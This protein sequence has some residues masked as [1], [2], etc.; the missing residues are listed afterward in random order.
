MLIPI[1]T[2]A[3][4]YHLP[5]MTVGLIALNTALFFLVGHPQ[6][7]M[8]SIG[9]GWH[10]LQWVTSA[11]LHANI[12]H[13]IGNMFFLW[14][15]GLVVEGKIG[16][17]RYLLTYLV[18]AVSGSFAAQTLF[19]FGGSDGQIRYALGASGAISGLMAIALLWAPENTFTVVAAYKY[20]PFASAS[21]HE[22]GILDFSLWFI[23]WDLFIAVLN[24]FPLS[25]P[26]LHLLGVIV[27][28]AVGVTFLQFRWVDCEKYDLFT[29]WSGT[30]GRP[31]Q[32]L[33]SIWKT[34]T[35]KRKKSS[36]KN[37]QPRYKVVLLNEADREVEP[38]RKPKPRQTAD[39]P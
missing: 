27:G 9:N 16:S 3:P 12:Y 19:G 21:D 8:L 31:L 22:L 26:V 37:R 20:G 11:F 7:W 14:A 34:T 25:T 29:R 10:P 5:V 38:S 39:A 30:S 24:R 33:A 18:M 1:G 28:F 17:W 35:R 4:I 6:E 15:Y 2:D 13:L 32:Q 23:G 36:V